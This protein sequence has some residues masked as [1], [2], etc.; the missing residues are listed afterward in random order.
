MT[1]HLVS[2]VT[3]VTTMANADRGLRAASHP[4]TMFTML[5]WIWAFNMMAAHRKAVTW[6][7]ASIPGTC[8]VRCVWRRR[9]YWRSEVLGSCLSC[10]R[11]A[12]SATWVNLA[13]SGV[14]LITNYNSAAVS[15]ALSLWVQTYFFV[16]EMWALVRAF[17]YSNS[18]WKRCITLPVICVVC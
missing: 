14:D 17:L 11:L 16:S 1:S 15:T 10:L 5:P 18:L 2:M 4:I 9:W 12:N 3:I 7:A 8:L 6:L 13:R